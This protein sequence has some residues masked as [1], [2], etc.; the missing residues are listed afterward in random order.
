MYIY[1]SFKFNNMFRNLWVTK[2]YTIELQI[3]FFNIYLYC[4]INNITHNVKIK[5]C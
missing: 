3:F 2:I 5:Y 4:G 1:I